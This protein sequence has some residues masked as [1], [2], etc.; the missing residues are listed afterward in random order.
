MIKFY[1]FWKR[2]STI[3]GGGGCYFIAFAAQL[4]FCYPEVNFLKISFCFVLCN[5]FWP[6][7]KLVETLVCC[8]PW[9]ADQNGWFLE[10]SEIYFVFIFQQSVITLG[11]DFGKNKWSAVPGWFESHVLMITNKSPS[12]YDLHSSYGIFQTVVAQN[13]TIFQLRAPG[14]FWLASKSLSKFYNQCL[15]VLVIQPRR[16]NLPQNCT[17]WR[18]SFKRYVHK[19]KDPRLWLSSK[20][21]LSMLTANIPISFLFVLSNV[22]VKT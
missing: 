20:W 9:L 14:D 13:L 5:E 15:Y 12:L 18:N 17:S 8:N 19:C 11:L 1:E 22:L 3:P 16:F 4:L 7:V 10:R 2:R 6:S 21:D